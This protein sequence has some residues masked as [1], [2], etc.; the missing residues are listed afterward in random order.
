MSSERRVFYKD[1]S[2]AYRMA[3]SNKSLAIA[4]IIVGAYA[5]IP[6]FPMGAL[7]TGVGALVIGILLLVR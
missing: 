4:A 3:I 5:L 2:I 7:V 6:W 1:S